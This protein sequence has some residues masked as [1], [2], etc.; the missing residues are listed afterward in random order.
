MQMTQEIDTSPGATIL[1]GNATAYKEIP[2]KGIMHVS[3]TVSINSRRQLVCYD[4]TLVSQVQPQHD[5][6]VSSMY[7][8][9]LFTQQGLLFFVEVT[10]AYEK[11]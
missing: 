11:T 6:H 1:T 7:R 3:I 2:L 4:N 8:L 10:A 5:Q 9:R